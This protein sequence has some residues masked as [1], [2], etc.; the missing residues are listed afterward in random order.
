MAQARGWTEAGLRQ[1]LGVVAALNADV[2]GA[3]ADPAFALEMAIRR[4]GEARAHSQRS[5]AGQPTAARLG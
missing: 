3:A 2:K 1:A 4:I 5:R